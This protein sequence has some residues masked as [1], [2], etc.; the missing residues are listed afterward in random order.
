[1]NRFTR[2]DWILGAAA[3]LVG[4]GVALAGA[5]RATSPCTPVEEL[6]LELTSHELNGAEV[7]E[8]PEHPI[9]Q[10]VAVFNQ[11]DSVYAVQLDDTQSSGR[12]SLLLTRSAP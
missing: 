11:E 9:V 8:P 4:L 5:A 12:R 3:F 10:L 1:M 6:S 2:H 7:A